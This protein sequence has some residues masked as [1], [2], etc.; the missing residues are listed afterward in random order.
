[1]H[2]L[3]VVDLNLR[4]EVA[5]AL[6]HL[7]GVLGVLKVVLVLTLDRVRVL[8]LGRELRVLLDLRLL[9]VLEAAETH[10]SLVHVHLWSVLEVVL[11]LLS[12]ADLRK[13]LS[14]AALG[15]LLSKDVV[16]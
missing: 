13:W 11:N 7:E 12:A 6:R 15:R 1:M 4:L 5:V 8:L 10:V 2:G 16:C 14:L 9:H 3:T